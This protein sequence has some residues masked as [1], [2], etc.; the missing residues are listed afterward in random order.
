MYVCMYVCICVC[1]VASY[2]AGVRVWDCRSRTYNAV[3]VLDEAKDSVTSL[4]VSTH[5][6]LT[7]CV[8][9]FVRVSLCVCVCAFF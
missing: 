9:C 2:D 3:Q 5:E 4:Q 8:H 7:G 1:V 6:I